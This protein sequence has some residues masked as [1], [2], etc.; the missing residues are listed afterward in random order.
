M[1]YLLPL[2]A[3]IFYGIGGLVN[4]KV[5]NLVDNPI[6]SSL[7]FNVA[8]V[9]VSAV[10]LIEDSRSGGIFFS[11]SSFDWVLVG[12]STAITLFAFWGMYAAMRE[13]PVSE[14]IL[15]S[16]ASIVTYTI[17]GFILFNERFTSVK[18]IGLFFVLIGIVLSSIRKGKFVFNKYVVLQLL[19]SIAFGFGVMI[20]KQISGNFSSGAYVFISTLIT[21]IFF[22]FWC[23]YAK[24]FSNFKEIPKVYITNVLIA[25]GFSLFAYYLLIKTYDLGG[26]VILT[27]ALGQIK[28]PIVVIGGYI[29]FKERT[30]LLTKFLGV[31]TVLIG[32]ILLKL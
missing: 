20:D 24:S 4:K 8:S 31:I 9:I 30:D 13:L 17:G 14:Q 12:A 15:L 22:F 11:T 16:R 6:L 1:V 28:I 21:T 5:A 26:L 29:F 25:G 3:G 32:L 27:G 10:L 19:S 18:L 2:L 23:L 7:L